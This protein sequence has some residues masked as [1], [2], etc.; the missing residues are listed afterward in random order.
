MYNKRMKVGIFGGTFNPPHKTHRQIALQAKN[1]LQLDKLIVVP[2]GIPPHK[3]CEVDSATRLQLAQLAFGDIAEVSDCEVVREGKSFTVDTLN[4]FKTQFSNA[5]LF[6]IIGGDSF[7]NFEKW[8]CPKEIA[9]LATLAV[10]DREEKMPQEVVEKVCNA[11]GA[12]AVF[13]DV[14]PDE[15]SST[16]VRLRYQFGFDNSVFVQPTVDRFIL[17][18]SLYANYRPI[19]EKLKNYLP[20]KRFMHTFYVVKRGLELANEQEKDEVFLACLL[21]DC[22]KYV[23]SENYGKYGFEQKNIPEPVVHSFL[24]ALVAKQD[25]G[26]D[27]EEILSAIAYHTTGCPNMSRLQKI[28]Y[29]ADKTEQTRPYPL[30]HLTKGTLDEQFLACLDEANSYTTAHHGTNVFPLTEETLQF[31]FPNRKK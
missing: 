28:V 9:Q 15:V 26:V 13:L 4:D 14:V 17:Q 19:A 23:S 27:D 29:V 2:C 12:K 20:Q 8:H 31:Y 21:H 11:V 18:N 16:D 3:S 5:Q 24:G 22:A 10:A 6:L 30:Q 7:V 1:Q 25:F